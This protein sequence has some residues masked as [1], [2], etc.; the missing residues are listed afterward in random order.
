MWTRGEG[1][2]NPFSHTFHSS[3][4]LRLW[5][6]DLG[7][8]ATDNPPNTAKSSQNSQA[9][10]QPSCRRKLIH[11]ICD[12]TSCWL[13]DKLLKTS[14]AAPPSHWTQLLLSNRVFIVGY[15]VEGGQRLSAGLPWRSSFRTWCTSCHL[16]LL[17]VYSLLHPHHY[18]LTKSGRNIPR[19][20]NTAMPSNTLCLL[21]SL[22]QMQMCYT[23][24]FASCPFLL[25]KS[26]FRSVS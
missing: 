4:R 21:I 22:S 8:K 1:S 17:P 15:N 11:K 26:V 23:L 6:R 13:S 5:W 12:W 16:C 10:P 18:T 25:V 20:R 2:I 19:Q 9:M 3:K 24:L 7:Y 14:D